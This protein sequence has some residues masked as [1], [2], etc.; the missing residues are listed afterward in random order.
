[1]RF[2]PVFLDLEG[3]PVLV[4]GG[5]EQAAQKVRLLGKTRARVRVLAAEAC[6]EIEAL[7]A[8]G[9]LTLERRGRLSARDVVGARLA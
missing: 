7:A 9:A 6:P 1:M 3:Q 8:G 5:G 2:F 4:V